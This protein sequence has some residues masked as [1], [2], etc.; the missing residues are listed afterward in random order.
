MMAFF[1]CASNRNKQTEKLDWFYQPHSELKRNQPVVA[2]NDELKGAS[3]C[4]FIA[5]LSPKSIIL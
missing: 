3:H 1:Q 4:C 2:Q 5:F